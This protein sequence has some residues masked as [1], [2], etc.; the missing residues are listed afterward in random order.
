MLRLGRATPATVDVLRALLAAEDATWGLRLVGE[1]GRPAGSVYPILAR[2]EDG[3]WLASSWDESDRR[4]A[5]RRLYALT[6]EGRASAVA[7]VAAARRPAARRIAEP[8]IA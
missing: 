3:G 6:D 7:V 5:R 1:T 2:L 4:G 8:G